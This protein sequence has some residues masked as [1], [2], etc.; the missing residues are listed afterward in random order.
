VANIVIRKH[1]VPEKCIRFGIC[2]S[3]SPI[4]FNVWITAGANQA[5]QRQPI[6]WLN[7]V[8]SNEIKPAYNL[9]V[10]DECEFVIKYP[11]E[12]GWLDLLVTLGWTKSYTLKLIKNYYEEEALVFPLE[13]DIE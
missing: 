7:G 10:D 12:S 1:I 2:F 9:L 6:T 4:V 11:I 13:E 3:D 8:P 5:R